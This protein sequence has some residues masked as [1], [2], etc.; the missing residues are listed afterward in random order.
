LSARQRLALATF[1]YATNGPDGWVH[2]P[3]GLQRMDVNQTDCNWFGMSL[4][5]QQHGNNYTVCN[6]YRQLQNLLL[7]N[8]NMSGILPEVEVGLLS[9]L[10]HVDVSD[11]TLQGIL[12][13]TLFSQWKNLEY[14]NVRHNHFTGQLPTHLGYLTN[15]NGLKGLSLSDNRFRGSLPSEIGLLMP[16]LRSLEVT[17]NQFSGSGSIPTQLG[18]SF[19]EY[20]A[21]QQLLGTQQQ[22]I[23]GPTSQ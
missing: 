8:R 10:R 18:A 5:Q 13:P 12:P 6:R 17:H 11:N 22:S 14:L 7:R 4:E 3:Q 1:Y 19:V 15:S 20:R 23:H 9:N 21:L 16:R 2:S